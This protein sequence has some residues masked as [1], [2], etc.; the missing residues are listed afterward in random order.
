VLRPEHHAVSARLDDGVQQPDQ[1]LLV[2]QIGPVHGDAEPTVDPGGNPAADRHGGVEDV[3]Q[4][5]RAAGGLH[6]RRWRD[7]E[8]RG[9][10][11]AARAGGQLVVQSVLHPLLPLLPRRWARRESQPGEVVARPGGVVEIEQVAVGLH[12]RVTGSTRASVQR[13]QPVRAV[14][15]TEADARATRGRLR[16]IVGEVHQ[17][18]GLTVA[19]LQPEPT[20]GQ[21]DSNS[22]CA[23]RADGRR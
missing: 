21:S 22:W 19:V 3:V 15:R 20:H 14:Q 1:V 16:E 23:S 18:R 6:P 7:N 13:L 11:D 17:L 10:A 4:L 5:Q 8:R 2:A 12:D 9:V